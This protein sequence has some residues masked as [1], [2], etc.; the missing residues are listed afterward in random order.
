VKALIVSQY[1]PLAASSRT[2]VF[3]YLPFLEANGVDVDLIVVVPDNLVISGTS[4]NTFTRISYY[5]KC[6]LRAFR[7]GLRCVLSASQYHIIY[8]QKVLLPVP[9]PQLLKGSRQKVLFDFDDAIFTT[10]APVE[11]WLARLRTLRHQSGLPSMLRSSGH[12]IVE[13]DYTGDH[14][15]KYGTK[16]Q[17]I[18]GPIDTTQYSPVPVAKST[19][20]VL[21]WIGSSST[22]R[23]LELI[24]K[25]LVEL[26]GRFPEICIRLIGA[27]DFSLEDLQMEHLPWSVDTELRDLR[28][29]HIGLMPLP[30]DPWTRGK[31]GY[32]LL[33]YMSLGIPAVASPVGVNTEIVEDGVDGFLAKSDAEWVDR[34]SELI[35]SDELRER[36][37]KAGRIKMKNEYSLQEASKKLLRTFQLVAEG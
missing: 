20:I 6:Y 3:Q 22:T 8:V 34:L 4:P 15:S 10:E 33:Q 14:A 1:G 29:F 7:A 37:G 30:D 21:G 11:S 2:R 27:G 19:R 28:T 16:V 31:G 23:Y 5:L 24:R 9:F 17:V 12:T 32:K 18:T 25:P 35:K 13:N 36:M 26:K